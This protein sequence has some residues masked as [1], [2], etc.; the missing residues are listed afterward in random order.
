M[1]ELL[2]E[3]LPSP[4]H[5]H[6]NASHSYWMWTKIHANSEQW[7]SYHLRYIL[8]GS[9]LKRLQ[10]HFEEGQHYTATSHMRSLL[11]WATLPLDHSI[12]TF[13]PSGRTTLKKV[14]THTST[15]AYKIQNDLIKKL[16]SKHQWT[17]LKGFFAFAS[18][19]VFVSCGLK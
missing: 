9:N 7:N 14:N 10:L 16:N 5:H 19:F 17:H 11:P 6:C 13:I 8:N 4:T 12:L 3:S 1:Q 2:R 18:L 15:Y